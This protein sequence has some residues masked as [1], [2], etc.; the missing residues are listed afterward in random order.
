MKTCILNGPE[1]LR[2][3]LK[4]ITVYGQPYPYSYG[5]HTILLTFSV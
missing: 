5:I 4:Y 3:G 2:K 1:R